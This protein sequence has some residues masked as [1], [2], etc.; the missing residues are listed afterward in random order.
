MKDTTPPIIS[1]YVGKYFDWFAL[2][3]KYDTVN[4]I[5]AFSISLRE[6]TSEQPVIFLMQKIKMN[7]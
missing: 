2:T 7:S 1:F 6:F 4:K 5:M 3:K